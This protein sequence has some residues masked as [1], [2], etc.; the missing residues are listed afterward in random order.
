MNRNIVSAAVFAAAALVGTAH[1][2][3]PIEAKNDF[4][5]AKTVAQV[6]AE[7]GQFRQAG[8]SPW[9]IQYNPLRAF[10]STASRAAVTADYIA[11]RD[12]VSAFNGEDSGSAWLQAAA[13]RHSVRDTLAGQPARAQ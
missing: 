13:P 12:Q 7:L 9:S 11:A 2:E 3:G 10:R 6:Q 1:A 4:V 5:S 8:V